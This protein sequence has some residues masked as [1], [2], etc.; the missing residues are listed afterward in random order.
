MV[1]AVLVCYACNVNEVW[2]WNKK[3]YNSPVWHGSWKTN[4]SSTTLN[5]YCTVGVTKEKP[6][7]FND[8][9]TKENK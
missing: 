8:F 1:S 6:R 2:L 5:K 9:S 4:A 3:W 7:D